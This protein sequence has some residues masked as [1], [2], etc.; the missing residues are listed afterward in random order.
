M[1]GRGPYKPGAK[2][3][4]AGRTPDAAAAKI[5]PTSDDKAVL[6]PRSLRGACG[7]MREYTH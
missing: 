7:Q 1:T 2:S 3:C 4:Q 6:P 5:H